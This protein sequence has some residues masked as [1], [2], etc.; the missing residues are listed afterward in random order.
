M[1]ELSDYYAFRDTLIASL[2]KDLL[3][4]SAPDEVI[5]DPPVTRYMCGILFPRD[6]RDPNPEAD[7]DLG[8][9]D[10]DFDEVVAPDPAVAMSNVLYPSSCGITFAVDRLAT[11]LI[12]VAVDCA[13]YESFREVRP[14]DQ[15]DGRAERALWR[16]V[17]LTVEPLTLHIDIP[18]RGERMAFAGHDGLKLFYR[19]RTGLET[20]CAMVTLVLLN[21]L[22]APRGAIRDEFCFFQPRIA[23]RAPGAISRP[24]IERRSR[25][26]AGADEEADT[27][28]LLYKENRSYAVG[29]GCSA[30]WVGEDDPAAFELF[31]SFAPTYELLISESNPRI[32][33]ISMR[34]LASEDRHGVLAGL[35]ALVVGYHDWI[36]ERESDLPDIEI[37]LVGVAQAH[38]A[39][40][41]AALERMSRG[42]ELLK[43]DDVSY[44]AFTLANSAMVQQ[45]TR[46]VRISQ[47]R[48]GEDLDTV[49]C[50]WRPF[51]VAFLLL[52]L[53][54]IIDPHSVDR[55]FVDLLWFPTG[56]GKTEAYLALIAFTV[57]LR[58]L[59]SGVGGVTALM[60]YTLR[61]LTAQQFERASSLVV[62]CEA[63]RQSRTDLGSEPISIG[64]WVG[65][66]G[67]PN[68]IKD[69]A[70]VLKALRDNKPT[71]DKG[72]PVQLH[73]CPWCGTP[74]DAHNY[75]VRDLMPR[76][77]VVSCKSPGC[78]FEHGLPVFVVDE[79][80]YEHRPTLLVGTVDKF[81]GLPWKDETGNI[82]N[83]DSGLPPELI[84]QDEL[85]LISGPLGT[86]TGLYETAVDAL[87]TTPE[88][89]GPKIV[90]ST[91]TIRRAGDQS[92]GLF[93]RDLRQFPPPGLSIN[94]SYFATT[95][96][97]SVKG[98]RL[99]AGFMA[100]GSSQSTLLIRAYA[101]LLQH[102][103]EIPGE[104]S[105]RDPYWTLVGYFNSLRV[106]GGARMQVQADVQER[107]QLL[108]GLSGYRRRASEIIVEM[109]SREASSAI[110]ERLKQ[111]KV[112]Y[113]D[114][115]AMD[116]VLATNMISV[117]VDIDRFGL[118]VIMGQP[119]S[120]SEYI[121][122]SSRVGRQ[123]PG[124]VITLFNAGR[125]RDR[126][127]Y[128]SFRTFHGALYRQV[129]ATSVTPFSSRARDRGLA[130][131]LIALARLTV[132]GLRPND[133]AGAI[134]QNRESVERLRDLVVRRVE[135]VSPRE[136]AA[137]RE[138]LD[139]I[140][141]LWES[142]ALREPNLSYSNRAHPDR[143]LLIDAARE[144]EVD[145]AI[146][147][148]WSLRDVDQTS[149]LYL[150]RT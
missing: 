150:V 85:H 49:E 13:R 7:N 107:I 109:T 61:L 67:T 43:L 96:P 147:A 40:C 60:R 8:N 137:T 79:D 48:P 29:H 92:L 5:V 135:R 24:F 146:P 69:A 35:E 144:G 31:T 27:Y 93:A 34:L 74:L 9:A 42:V 11:D 113:P 90:A 1:P 51:Q 57:F 23:V 19:V 30:D 100:P 117:G 129:E 130:P 141:A 55:Q 127:H 105:V 149:N 140:I 38:L 4:P 76:R 112:A 119:Q 17:P 95:A 2:E 99:Y 101:A 3:G 73:R 72:N 52:C 138:Q 128:E 148:L 75:W 111:M 143:A 62:A 83:I 145:G 139:S 94:D 18:N 91:A 77:L 81:A 124:L 53:P 87:C 65:Q 16:R 122:A 68:T 126:S 14:D 110:P 50:E 120:A 12:E 25:G 44:R 88:G 116:V 125:S 132:P 123:H 59:R 22:A 121:Q 104:D 15:V 32:S 70:S 45:R 26:L 102:A 82:F 114:R 84:V 86:L 89:I 71:G 115:N 103:L 56:G 97:S 108:A 33:P 10:A 46:A 54:G 36:A 98:A 41:S 78:R 106:L 37:G 66:G 80:I 131:V 134:S 142:R 20:D 64:L 63:I 39:E 6:S 58:R 136:A 28:R 21:S 118:M 133:S 47:G